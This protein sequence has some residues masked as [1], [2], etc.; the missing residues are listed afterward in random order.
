MGLQQFFRKGNKAKKTVHMC[1]VNHMEYGSF[2]LEVNS[3]KLYDILN[4]FFQNMNTRESY[5]HK[6]FTFLITIDQNKLLKNM[7]DFFL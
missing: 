4:F 7:G 6:R 1:L 2:L 5:K 3:S